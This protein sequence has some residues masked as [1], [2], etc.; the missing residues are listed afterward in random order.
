M[1]FQSESLKIIVAFIFITTT[2]DAT[3]LV[4]VR[5]THKLQSRSLLFPPTAPTRVQF[6][7][8]IGIPVEDLNFESVTSGYVLK[9]EYFLPET[10]D[11]FRQKLKPQTIHR[12]RKS[13]NET[14]MYDENFENDSLV[15]EVNSIYNNEI[16]NVSHSI[17]HD[18]LKNHLHQPKDDNIKSQQKHGAL[19]RWIVYKAMETI[20]NKSALNGHAC[21][22]RSIC[23]HAAIPLNYEGGLLAEILHIILTPS[24][25]RDDPSKPNHKDYLRAEVLGRSGEDCERVYNQCTKSPMEII[26]AVFET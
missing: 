3:R 6:I 22:L 9:A 16:W 7:G 18:G 13:I 17:K 25:S 4:N 15:N 14:Y 23:E 21:M 10:A 19:Y 20:L 1:N 2:T 12:R 24:T 8:G 11:E 5:K 26:S